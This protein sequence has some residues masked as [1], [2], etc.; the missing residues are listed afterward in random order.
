MV[1]QV[2]QHGCQRAVVVV[3]AIG[4][5]DR[6]VQHVRVTRQ[7]FPFQVALVH[8]LDHL[9]GHG[10]QRDGRLHARSVLH[11]PHQFVDRRHGCMGRAPFGLGLDHHYQHIG[12]GGVVVDDELVVVVVARIRTQFRRALIEVADLQVL[13]VPEAA[14]EGEQGQDDGHRGNL[15]IGESRQQAPERVLAGRILLAAGDGFFADADIGNGDW[16]QDQ[17][18]EHDH[19]H[20][21]GRTDGQLADH[22]DIDDQQGDETHGVGKDGDHARQEQLAECTPGRG[23][24]IVGIA[25]LQRDTVDLLYAMGNTDGENQ[26]RHQH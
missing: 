18:G 10:H 15:G 16:Q 1:V 22:A 13:A 4:T 8:A 24:G 26:E 5:G 19:G 9:L 11:L 21:D 14:T 20:T 23:Q 3:Q 25:G 12:A 6:V 2:N 7:G 17:V